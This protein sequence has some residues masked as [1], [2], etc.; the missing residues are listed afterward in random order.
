M[1]LA[2]DNFV[3]LGKLIEE[4]KIWNP[5]LSDMVRYLSGLKSS[6]RYWMMENFCC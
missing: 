6:F 3:S 2:R 1:I 4:R 5:V